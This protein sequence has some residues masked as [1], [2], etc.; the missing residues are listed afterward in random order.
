MNI[1]MHILIIKI[2]PTDLQ[3]IAKVHTIHIKTDKFKL[4][5]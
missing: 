5:Y 1:E 2:S 4:Y 3:K